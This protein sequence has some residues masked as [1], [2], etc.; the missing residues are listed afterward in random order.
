MNRIPYQHFISSSLQIAYLTIRPASV[1][2]LL[3]ICMTYVNCVRLPQIQPVTK[4]TLLSTPVL[5]SPRLP[6]L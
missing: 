5:M 6:L 4:L 3:C 1:S 2:D